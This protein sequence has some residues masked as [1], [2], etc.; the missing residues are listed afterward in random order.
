LPAQAA[1]NT[2]AMTK[3]IL[4][5]SRPPRDASYWAEK[6]AGFDFTKSDHLD[7]ERFNRILWAG[8]KGEN[9]PYPTTRS[10]RDLRKNRQKLLADAVRQED[11]R[12][13]Q[14]AAVAYKTDSNKVLS[15]AAH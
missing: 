2:L 1:T 15:D 7:T 6:L 8:L 10:G 5:F 11:R 3:S 9:I 13:K 4:A 14:D 12:K